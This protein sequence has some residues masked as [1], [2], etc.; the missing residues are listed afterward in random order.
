MSPDGPAAAAGIKIG[1]VLHAIDGRDVFRRPIKDFAHVITSGAS[2][3][4]VDLTLIRKAHGDS[5]TFTAR[6]QRL[7]PATATPPA[8]AATAFVHNIPVTS[9]TYQQQQPSSAAFMPLHLP[10]HHPASASPPPPAAALRVSPAAP[11]QWTTGLMDVCSGGA[12]MFLDALFCGSCIYFQLLDELSF[13]D[14]SEEFVSGGSSWENF[15]WAFR[16]PGTWLNPFWS[17]CGHA[18]LRW[19]IA[20]RHN[21]PVRCS[22]FL[23]VAH[24]PH[25][26]LPSAL[27]LPPTG[28]PALRSYVRHHVLWH[29]RPH[30][31]NEAG[32]CAAM[33]YFPIIF[34]IYSE[35]QQLLLFHS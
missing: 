25:S 24:V 33:V 30:P 29:V 19:R 22:G 4:T 16:I 14:V 7:E 26:A 23:P 1:D 8:P 31:G 6:V 15:C 3:S 21:I 5:R 11:A 9:G 10:Y 13:N 35:T 12:S 34:L 20:K 2:G 17:C 27:T 32:A 18:Q 28:G